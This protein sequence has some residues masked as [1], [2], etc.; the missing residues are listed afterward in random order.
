[1]CSKKICFRNILKRI[2]HKSFLKGLNILLKND[3]VHGEI[4][5]GVGINTHFLNVVVFLLPFIPSSHI[6]IK[7]I[8][9]YFSL[10]HPNVVA[11]AIVAASLI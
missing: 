1:M 4:C 8:K 5:W 11:V 3:G 10:H 9:F 2:I 6:N 7:N